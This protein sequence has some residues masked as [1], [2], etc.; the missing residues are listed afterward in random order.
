MLW[1][2]RLSSRCPDRDWTNRRSRTTSRRQPQS[3]R[4]LAAQLRIGGLPDLA[5]AAFPEEGGDVVVADR[6]AGA[7]GHELSG[8]VTEPF[9]AQAVKRVHRPAQKCP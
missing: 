5:H 3:H 7:E 9:Y 1:S 6:G 4:D 8:T 2:M